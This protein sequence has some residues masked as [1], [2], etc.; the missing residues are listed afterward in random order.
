MPETRKVGDEIA[1]T[2]NC[3]L[4][5]SIKRTSSRNQAENFWSRKCSKGCEN[6]K[7]IYMILDERVP[8]LY[9]Y[10]FT[11]NLLNYSPVAIQRAW[12]IYNSW[13]DANDACSITLT[14]TSPLKCSSRVLWIETFDIKTC[15]FRLKKNLKK[16][17]ISAQKRSTGCQL[18]MQTVDIK[19]GKIIWIETIA[20]TRQTWEWKSFYKRNQ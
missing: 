4:R 6:R 8:V 12:K 20:D 9:N 16:E 19:N 3:S 13:H 1:T 10:L 5:I 14:T 17:I 15:N 11:A 7:Q 18:K 2:W